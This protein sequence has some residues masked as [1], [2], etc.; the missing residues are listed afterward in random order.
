[1]TTSSKLAWGILGTGGIAKT[2]A[3]A[4]N[5]SISGTLV[6]VASRTQASADEFAKTYSVPKAY[7]GYDKLLADPAVQAVYISLP[8]HMHAEWTVKCALAGKHILCEKPF[9]T[10]YPEA[11]YALAKVKETGVFFM[12]AFMYRTH[13][14]IA[15]AVELIKSGAIGQIRIINAAFG[16]NMGPS[17]GNIRLRQDAAGGAIMDVGCYAVSAARLFAGA[18][19]NKPFA[20]PLELRGHGF[21]GAT[22]KVDEYATASLRFAPGSVG[23]TSDTPPAGDILANVATASQVNLTNTVTI[24]GSTG[25]IH[26]PVPWKPAESASITLTQNGKDP[27]T[28]TFDTGSNIY[29][30]Q[31]DA[32]AKL[33]A[34]GKKEASSPAMSIDD[35]LGNMRTLDLWRQQAGLVFDSEKPD[36]IKTTYAGTP[37]KKNPKPEIPHA[38]IPG[39]AKPIS[40]IVMGT[41]IYSPSEYPLTFAMLDYFY[42]IGGNCLDTAHLYNVG[43]SEIACGKWINTRGIREQIVLLGKGC[44]TPADKPEFITPQLNLT[45]ERLGTSYLDLYAL[46]RDNIKY[47]VSEFIEPLEEHRKAGRIRAYGGSNWSTARL[48][49]ANDYCKSKGYPGFQLSSPNFSLAVWNQPMWAGCLT[50]SDKPS[51]QWYAQ[52]QVPIF[53]WSSQASG[54]FAGRITPETASSPDW[55]QRDAHR[56]WY[57]DENAKRLHRARELAK[58]KNTTPTAIAMAYVLNQPFPTF[59]LIGPRSIEETRTSSMGAN[60]KLTP[61]EL[62]FLIAE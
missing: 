30:H 57:N 56:A 45:L 17:Y 10:N 1:M 16:Y 13:P 8:N 48:Q 7:E 29:I 41:M 20:D 14:Q 2:L 49:E 39:C 53:S 46:H 21:I 15:K 50:A 4:I 3:S 43:Q 37:L 9:T 62:N 32:V 11:M 19:Q 36:A 25:S 27:Q 22:S 6:A 58:K 23:V 5:K 28:L 47:P 51:R 24:F 38:T 55:Y 34:E 31:I 59:A 35:S 61:E 26:I 18:A 40:R 54:F 52:S 12:E 44:H 33:I 42:E 60:L